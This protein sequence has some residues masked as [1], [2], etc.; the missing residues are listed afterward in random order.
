MDACRH[1]LNTE[2]RELSAED[3]DETA[4]LRS[5]NTPEKYA[6]QKYQYKD[7]EAKEAKTPEWDPDYPRSI[8]KTPSEVLD[9]MVDMPPQSESVE[10]AKLTKRN[11]SLQTTVRYLTKKNDDKDVRIEQYLHALEVRANE[12]AR[13]QEMVARYEDDR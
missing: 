1:G 5:V 13:L 2:T 6:G 12:V 10:L 11:A 8:G 4:R 7:Y 9:E 3:R